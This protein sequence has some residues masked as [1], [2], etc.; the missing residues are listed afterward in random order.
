M[1]GHPCGFTI[2]STWTEHAVPHA[3]DFLRGHQSRRLENLD[4]LLEAR[5]RHRERPGELADRGI[6]ASKPLE[7]AP[8]CGIRERRERRVE[9]FGKVNH[10]VQYSLDSDSVAS[11]F[12]K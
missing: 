7:D 1:F 6:P 3:S 8:S 2:Q 12:S 11:W 10:A 9:P 5:Q 4:V